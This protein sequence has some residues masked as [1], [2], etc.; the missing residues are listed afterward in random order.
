[1]A[2]A[3]S[4]DPAIPPQKKIETCTWS[5]P[6][7]WLP[8]GRHCLGIIQAR[9]RKQASFS[10]QCSKVWGLLGLEDRGGGDN[11]IQFINFGR[12]GDK[13]FKEWEQK[14]GGWKGG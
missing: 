9:R 1:M 5:A 13:S 4:S 2:H 12:M 6:L 3:K 7:R 11:N 10:E 14:I 8:D